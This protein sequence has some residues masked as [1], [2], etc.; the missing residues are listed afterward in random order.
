MLT[1]SYLLTLLV[2]ARRLPIM[3]DTLKLPQAHIEKDKLALVNT[4]IRKHIE[5]CGMFAWGCTIKSILDVECKVMWY[6]N[7]I[8]YRVLLTFVG[9]VESC[10]NNVSVNGGLMSQTWYSSYV[11][12]WGGD[13]LCQWVVLHGSMANLVMFGCPSHYSWSV[14]MFEFVHFQCHCVCLWRSYTLKMFNA[15]VGGG[16]V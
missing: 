12:G 2:P 16:G 9:L 8:S 4:R 11:H 1:S 13:V 6:F 3:S 14:L 10:V 5:V 7:F 15:C